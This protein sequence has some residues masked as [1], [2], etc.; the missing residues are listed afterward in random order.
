M[1]KVVC[2]RLE[3]LVLLNLFSELLNN[4]S[5]MTSENVQK[6]TGKVDN[7]DRGLLLIFL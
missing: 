5:I 1:S 7:T 3:I 4:R 2:S 6:G